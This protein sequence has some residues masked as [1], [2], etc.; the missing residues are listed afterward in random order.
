MKKLS[1]IAA[2]FL[3]GAMM[4]SVTA[5]SSSTA[6]SSSTADTS[7]SSSEASET[8]SEAES[9]ADASSEAGSSETAEGGTVQAI[10]DRGYIVMS[11]N[12]EFEPFEYM[13]GEEFKGID[14]E[15]SQKIAD[16]LGVELRINN[17]SFDSLP[18][19]LD[20]DK[21][22]FVAAGM[23]IDPEKA[24]DFS[25]SYFS[26]SQS[27]IV[28]VDSDIQSGDDLAGKKIGVQL[29]TTGDTYC[30][31]NIEGA[32][33][34]RMSKGMDAVA[35]LIRG[36]IDAVVIDNYPATKL[37]EKN[38]EQVKMLDEALTEEE[39]GIAV[40]KG[41]QELLDVINETLA[42]LKESGEMDTILE[43]YLGDETAE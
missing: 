37:V 28:R 8:S 41:N 1:K 24:I 32:E 34:S 10:K 6:S 5:C 29:G 19:E 13:V 2:L 11:T 33:V 42:E 21:C 4:L 7:S 18:L 16:K 31:E 15:I 9:S 20:T 12:A 26:A 23:T 22:D 17:T 14:I 3:T 36:S 25:D 35:D 38:S 40:K 30:T 43:S 27:I 39:Y